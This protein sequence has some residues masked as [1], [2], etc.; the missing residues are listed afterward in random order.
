MCTPPFVEVKFEQ[1]VL[2]ERAPAMQVAAATWSV[3][4]M[5]H[6][7]TV[8]GFAESRCGVTSVNF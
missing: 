6:R 7:V 1:V 3:G 4:A 8:G 2:L 5:V